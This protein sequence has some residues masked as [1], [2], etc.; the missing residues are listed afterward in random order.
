MG[1]DGMLVPFFR[2]S[3][4]SQIKYCEMSYFITYNLGYQQETQKKANLGTITHKVFEILASCKK[5][6]QDKVTPR[7]SIM[8]DELGKISF[9]ISSLYT[10]D[11]VLDL[12]KRSFDHYSKAHVGTE[13]SDEDY[14]FCLNMVNNGILHANGLFDPRNR[15]IVATEPKFDI[16]IEEDWAKFKIDGEEK[17][18]SIKGSIDLVTKINDDTIEMI[19]WKALPVETPIPTRYGWTTMGDITIGEIIFDKDGKQ[20]RVIGKSTPKYNYCY[21]FIFD[22]TTEVISDEDHIWHM[23]NG[24]NK[25][26]KE[27]I[28]G[29][30]ISVTKPLEIED[31]DLPIDPYVLG[32]WLGN[33]RN[34]CGAI[35]SSDDFV[36]D[37]IERRGYTLGWDTEKDNDKIKTRTVI[38]LTTKLRS[39]SLLHN[40]HI[41]MIYLRASFR[42]R[43]DLLRGL[44]DSDGNANPARKQAVF[45]ST[46]KTLSND[47]MQLLLGLGQRVNQGDITRSTNFSEN[48]QVYPLHFRPQHNINP[49]LLPRKADKI[50]LE[51]GPGKSNVRRIK[52]IEKLNVIRKVQCI[53]V[54]S[55]SNTYLCTHN[56]IPTHNT[57]QRKNWATGKIKTYEDLHDDIQLLLYHYAI[58]KLYP[59][60][61]QIIPSI[62]FLRDGGPFSLCFDERDDEKFIKKLRENFEYIT[63]NK[64][65]KPINNWRNDFRCQK[66]CTFYKNKWDGT[67]TRM[68]NYVENHI[69]TY[70]IDVTQKQLK[71]EDFT[72]GYYAAPGQVSK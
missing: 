59:E 35:T 33:G 24:I 58:R 51:W 10:Y 15:N 4:L 12:L 61:K 17:Y 13:Y 26:T 25:T 3:S 41:P 34:R 5:K 54:N 31:T 1:V 36:F 29:D 38:G 68:C 18:L 27:I 47:V 21:K 46:E 60:Y 72:L 14:K 48:V 43:L 23:S 63:N 53:M 49:F 69:K 42:Q 40:K 57:G 56:M 22:D 16:T 45:T 55:P 28:P 70:G 39:L 32:Y 52:N 66:L 7:M 64:M 19:D 44:M 6:T 30:Q 20:T 71:K 11:F 37:E 2:S 62:F 9:T 8:D 50:N 65:P 67:N